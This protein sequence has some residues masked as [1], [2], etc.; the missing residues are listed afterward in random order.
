MGRAGACILTQAAVSGSDIRPTID[1]RQGHSLD[2]KTRA[3]VQGAEL[4]RMAQDRM[5][6]RHTSI[7]WTFKLT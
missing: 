4:L 2:W 1:Q 5:E 7:A 3:K 6:S